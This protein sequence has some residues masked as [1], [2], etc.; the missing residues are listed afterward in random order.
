M[1]MG[2]YARARMFM[3]QWLERQGLLQQESQPPPMGDGGVVTL[4]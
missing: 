4:Q 1:P 2:L 3:V